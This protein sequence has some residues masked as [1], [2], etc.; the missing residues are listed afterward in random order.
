ME[1]DAVFASLV[2]LQ[3]LSADEHEA[4]PRESYA[5]DSDDLQ[6]KKGGM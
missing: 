2:R 4:I 3:S 5:R 1:Q 6:E